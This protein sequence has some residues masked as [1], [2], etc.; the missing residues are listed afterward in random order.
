MED[1]GYKKTEDKPQM[2]GTAKRVLLACATMFS[3]ATFIY[4]TISAYYFVHQDKDS[5][6]ETIKSPE[7]PIKIVEE[8]EVKDEMQVN[9]GIYEDIFGNKQGSLKQKSVKI[10]AHS[11]PA[12][13]SKNKSQDEKE[14]VKEEQKILVYSTDK[15]EPTKQILTR[16]VEKRDN[17]AAPPQP[18]SSGK[19]SV[20]V[21]IAA[22]SSQEA[23]LES[24]RKLENR[25]S[26][27]FSGLKPFVEKVDLG[28]RGI[29][30]RLQIGNFPDQI[31][32]ETFCG[33]YVSQTRKSS[34]DCIVVE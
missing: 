5:D 21:Q 33:R 15:K 14:L 10:R 17:S 32:A 2:P 26:S 12:L 29:F 28:K 27:L 11:E 13:P 3:L 34:A 8:E 24:W 31:S 4:I 22:M 19:R 25:N 9:R 16:D 1:F 18:K 23:A 7:G 20:K 30:Y 6:I